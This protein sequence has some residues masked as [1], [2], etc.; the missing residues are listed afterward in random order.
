MALTFTFYN[1]AGLTQTAANVSVLQATDGTSPAVDRVVYL[2]STAAG[3]KLQAFVDPG[4]DPVTVG[5][6]DAATGSGVEAAHVRLAASQAGLDAA[7][8][9]ASLN[10]AAQILSGSVNA[11]A[12]WLRIDTPALVAGTYTDLSLITG[13]CVESTV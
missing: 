1:D 12:V 10:L 9:G 3:K 7:T 2:G 4:V 11:V 8:P 13:E 5:L 6:A